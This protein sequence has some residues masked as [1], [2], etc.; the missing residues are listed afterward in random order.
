MNPHIFSQLQSLV[1]RCTEKDAPRLYRSLYQLSENTE[2]LN[3]QNLKEW[4]Q[5]PY[6]TKDRLIETPL[7]D[8]FFASNSDVEDMA[9]SSGTS[10]KPPLFVPRAGPRDL[11]YR[12]KYH[13]FKKAI[14][15]F[16]VPGTPHWHEYLQN[17]L[18]YTPRV[19]SYDP[20]HAA[21]SVA[22][23]R[24][25]G[26]DSICVFTFHVPV[27]GELMKSAGIATDIRFIEMC[28]EICTRSLFAYI[29]TTFPNATILPQYGSA[30]V[31]DKPLGIPCRAITGEEPLSVYHVKKS[32]YHELID[33]ETLEVLPYEAG[34]E[35]ELV[36]S[37]FPKAPWAT[38]IIR[39]RTGDMVRVLPEHCAIHGELLFIMIGRASLDFIKIPGG[40][41]RAD[42]IGRVLRSL[43]NEKIS[44]RFEMHRYI[45]ENTSGPKIKAV[46]HIDTTSQ[47]SPEQLSDISNSIANSLRVGPSRTYAEGV[48]DGM[49]LPLACVL[50][51]DKEQGS[52]KSKCMFAH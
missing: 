33:P 24:I 32:Q 46:L 28:G 8:R 49:Y 21:A 27:I 4:E 23:A 7:N 29:R 36:V 51:A 48:E 20:K 3:I 26:V 47:L 50:L 25:A 16:K 30:E 5:L 39:Y 37:A 10:G 17:S 6:L 45:E 12:L 19:I 52:G 22:L 9:A 41:L 42:E 43:G 35:G 2:S 18:G 13:S 1:S 15:A 11:E 40:M 31:E 14:L 38:P 34:T 44:D